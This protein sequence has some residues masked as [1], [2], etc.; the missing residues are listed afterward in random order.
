MEGATW[1]AMVGVARDR[2]AKLG[3]PLFEIPPLHFVQCAL[4][5]TQAYDQHTQSYFIEELID[6]P[7][8]KYIGYGSA[9]ILLSSCRTPE[10]ENVAAFL[11]FAQYQQYNDGNLVFTSHYQGMPIIFFICHI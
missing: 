3:L 6:G 10:H 8:V 7:F 2:D 5:K 1:G 9:Q 4:A 11:S